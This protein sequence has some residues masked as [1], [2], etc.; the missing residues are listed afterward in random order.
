ML[1]FILGGV[2]LLAFIVVAFIYTRQQQE[3]KRIEQMRQV[4][5]LGDRARQ[6][7]VLLDEIPPQF[8]SDDFKLFLVK[9]WQDL[10]HEQKALDTGKSNIDAQLEQAEQKA[11]EIHQ[12]TRQKAAPIDDIKVA[13]Q[14]RKNLKLLHKTLSDLYKDRKLN[15]KTAQGFIGEIKH[16]FT[17]SLIEVY[18]SAAQKAENEGKLRIAIL[19]YQRII[20]ELNKVNG[21]GLYNQYILDCKKTI[22]RLEQQ[23]ATAEEQ[24]SQNSELNEALDQMIEDEDSWKKK[25]VYDN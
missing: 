1:I 6:I 14:V 23:Q 11:E 8:L 2:L 16:G 19:Q 13:N 18:S 7:S 3:K 24:S 22:E 9:Q 4:R 25:Q 5:A 21:Q 17:R 12:N 20:N 15:A 10:L